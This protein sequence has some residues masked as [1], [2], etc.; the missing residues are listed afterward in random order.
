MA[1]TRTFSI[2]RPER[3]SVA[4]RAF[5]FIPRSGALVEADP[6]A[7]ALAELLEREGSLTPGEPIEEPL[8]QRFVAEYFDPRAAREAIEGFFTY[9]ILAGPQLVQISRP[10]VKPQPIPVKHL[11]TS[12]SQ[13]CNLRCGYCYADFGHYRREPDMMQVE[14][15]RKYVDFLLENAGGS[16]QVVYTF[17]GGE[18]L[19][20][21]PVIREAV[22]YGRSR[23]AA[24]GTHIQFGLTTN[25]TVM[26]QEMIDFFV[27]EE[28]EV[29]ISVDGS[30]KVNDRLRPLAGGGGSFALLADRIT[31]L[32]KRRPTPARVTVTNQ[33]LDLADTF[34]ALDEMGFYEVGFS[35]VSTADPRFALS[36][37]DRDR[38]V[39]ELEGLSHRTLETI[40]KGRLLGFSNLLQLIRQIHEAERH[41][42]PCG[43][44]MS[45]LAGN[46]DGELY[47]CHRLIND[48]EFSMGSVAK[49]VD[50]EAQAEHLD[51]LHVDQKIPCASCW[52]QGLCGGGCY[53]VAKTETGASSS[54]PFEHCDSIRRWYRCGIE[55]YAHL[56]LHHAELLPRIVRASKTLERYEQAPV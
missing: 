50:R 3:F 17:F 13:A 41:E 38:F 44:G 16:P 28:I 51:R 26:T 36:R 10:K 7:L 20:N 24:V 31:P 22:K 6:A 14:T 19:L 30:P 9:G 8:L 42:H 34:G 43:A 49:G 48:T 27:D 46:S 25:G 53:A 4:G 23:Q 35:P 33:N 2:S 5:F 56:N 45:L 54:V 39:D 29:T 47:A 52:A 40:P 55:S 32:L 1:T 37:A 15:A 18:P 12:V 11:I 21:F